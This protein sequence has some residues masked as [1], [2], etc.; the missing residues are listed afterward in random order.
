MRIDRPDGS[1]GFG[2][3]APLPAFGTETV[4][5]AEACCRSLGDRPGD[6]VLSRVP[7]GLRSL[8]NAL[9]FAIGGPADI[10]RHA[11]LGVAALL[12]AGRAA[13]SEAPPKAEAGFR[14]LNG[15]W[16]SAHPRMKWPC[17]TT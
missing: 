7:R 12:P 11:S 16:V 13:L 15:R 4:D 14:V 17:W 5:E 3:A 9:A 6:D 10:P 2:E 8:R 1:V